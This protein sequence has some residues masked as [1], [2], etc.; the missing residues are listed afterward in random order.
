MDDGKESRHDAT[1]SSRGAHSKAQERSSSSSS[2]DSKPFDNFSEDVHVGDWKCKVSKV[3]AINPEGR[4]KLVLDTGL[5]FPDQTLIQRVSVKNGKVK[6]GRSMPLVE[7]DPE[8]FG[9]SFRLQKEGSTTL[10]DVYV[11]RGREYQQILD[12]L[13]SH[14]ESL[15]PG[16]FDGQASI[17]STSSRSNEDDPSHHGD[18]GSILASGDSIPGAEP[19]TA[20]NTT[21]TDNGSTDVVVDALRTNETAPSETRKRAAAAASLK[22]FSASSDKSDENMIAG[23]AGDTPPSMITIS[24][25]TATNTFTKNDCA[26]ITFDPKN[27]S[28]PPEAFD[29]MVDSPS[30]SYGHNKS[31]STKAETKLDGSGMKPILIWNAP[32]EGIAARMGAV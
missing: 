24:G 30:V 32:T 16:D 4:I 29:H 7:S 28:T 6:L 8:D 12:G 11:D 27:E 5:G 14:I 20:N 17:A 19:S 21:T 18:G 22:S 13:R 31:R 25:A 15:G 3:L 2:F 9:V 23:N 1:A 10:R 26:S